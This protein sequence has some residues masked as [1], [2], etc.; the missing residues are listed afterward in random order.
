[1]LITNKKYEKRIRKS[2]HIHLLKKV[3]RD[4]CSLT[5]TLPLSAVN[6][7]GLFYLAA[8]SLNWNNINIIDIVST[9][10]EMTF[11]VNEEDAEKAFRALHLLIKEKN[12]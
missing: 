2:F 6:T 5:I 1:M 11:I 3:I 9:M 4:I 8:R 10:T 7:L 12:Y